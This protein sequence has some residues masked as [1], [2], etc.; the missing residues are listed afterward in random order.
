MKSGYTYIRLAV[1]APAKPTP[2]LDRNIHLKTSAESS[3]TASSQRVLG[4]SP[5][6][7]A[8]VAEPPQSLPF[9]PFA[10]VIVIILHIIVAVFYCTKRNKG[11]DA[12]TITYTSDED[13]AVSLQTSCR[14]H[15]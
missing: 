1:E 14:Q 9:V 15:I 11:P 2:K 12:A 5:L 6:N 7:D 4:N 3:I 10:L 8:D 13:G